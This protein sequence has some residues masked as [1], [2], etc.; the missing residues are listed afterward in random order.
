MNRLTGFDRIAVVRRDCG[1]VW[2]SISVE[3]YQYALI[4]GVLDRLTRIIASPATPLTNFAGPVPAPK[5]QPAEPFE[6]MTLVFNEI[7]TSL[8]WLISRE[9]VGLE[10]VSEPKPPV[11][12]W[13]AKNQGISIAPG[14]VSTIAE[15]WLLMFSTVIT[16]IVPPQSSG[17]ISI[18]DSEQ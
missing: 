4:K 2:F 5:R 15:A 11:A 12:K 16:S 1:T 8:A 14:L 7:S 13:E 6:A 18:T 9:G 17:N 10:K 3:A